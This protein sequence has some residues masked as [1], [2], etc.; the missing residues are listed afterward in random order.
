MVLSAK[1]QA[2]VESY[3][4]LFNAT[5]AYVEV[6]GP[7]SRKT[8]GANGH[9]LLKNAEIEAAI[10]QRLQASAMSADEVLMRLADQARADLGDFLHDDGEI[11]IAAMKR[12]K[13]TYLLRKIKRTERTGETESGGTWAETRVEVELHDAQSA[14]NLIGRHHK[15]FTDKIEHDVQGQMVVKVIEGVRDVR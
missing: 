5:E 11:D 14:L 1:H 3:L 9:R 10:Q 4:R 8:A 7:K 12:A 6:Y 13:K 2:F 15:L